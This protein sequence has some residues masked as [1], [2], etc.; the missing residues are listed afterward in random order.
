MAQMTATCHF[1]V[2]MGA[3]LEFSAPLIIEKSHSD[4]TIAV[5]LFWPPSQGLSSQGQNMPELEYFER[6]KRSKKQFSDMRVRPQ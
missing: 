4:R 6:Q 3:P 2:S 5:R 1:R